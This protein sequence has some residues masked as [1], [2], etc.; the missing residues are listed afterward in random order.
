MRVDGPQRRFCD[1]CR[2]HVHD[3]SSMSQPEAAGLVAREDD[4]CCVSYLVRP[5]GS[6]VTRGRWGAL[7]RGWMT[8]RGGILALLATVAPVLFTS[9]ARH[10][11]C[12]RTGGKV[13]IDRDGKDSPPQPKPT[14]KA[15]DRTIGN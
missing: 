10:Q 7:A 5:D 1:Q 2:L 4:Q 15:A 9:C 12:Y 14:M 11:D 8:L 13:V 3:L 6:M